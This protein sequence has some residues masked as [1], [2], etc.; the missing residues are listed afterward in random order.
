[1]CAVWLA[2][3]MKGIV[4]VDH[5]LGL[6]RNS[7][8]SLGPSTSLSFFFSFFLSLHNMQH[9]T[10]DRAHKHN[11]K[12]GSIYSTRCRHMHTCCGGV[13]KAASEIK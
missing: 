13:V 1:M 2:I 10:V 5:L 3:V 6:G 12:D 8:S 11:S 4:T 9:S 7:L